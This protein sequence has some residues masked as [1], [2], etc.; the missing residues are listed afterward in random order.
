MVISATGWFLF[1][2]VDERL[3][4]LEI[5][6]RKGT[7]VSYLPVGPACRPLVVNHGI[8]DSRCHYPI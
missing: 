4:S 2:R 7:G 1:G 8:G 3:S 6:T 5:C